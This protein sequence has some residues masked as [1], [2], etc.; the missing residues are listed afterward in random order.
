MTDEPFAT[1]DTSVSPAVREK[2]NFPEYHRMLA[3]YA[4]YEI[5]LKLNDE[6]RAEHYNKF[7]EMRAQMYSQIEQPTQHYPRW[8]RTRHA[9]S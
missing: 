2:G 9:Y 6:R 4:T 5:M 1:M 7:V 8:R 3:F